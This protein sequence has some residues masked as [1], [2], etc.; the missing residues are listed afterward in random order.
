MGRLD[1]LRRGRRRGRRGG[2]CDRRRRGYGRHRGRRGRGSRLLLPAEEALLALRETLL[3]LDHAL[4]GRGDCLLFLRDAL[5]AGQELLATLDLLIDNRLLLVQKIEDFLLSRDDFTLSSRNLPARG[6]VLRVFAGQFLFAADE[7]LDP[8]RSVLLSAPKLRFLLED[9]LLRCLEVLLALP[10]L[11]LHRREFL[12]PGA[13]PLLTTDDGV[14][15]IGE[16]R[17]PLPA[18]APAALARASPPSPRGRLRA[19]PPPS[20]GS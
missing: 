5:L 8:L 20:R 18:R 3:L 16:R 19:S 12:F 17:T 13:K 2:S 14:P 6:G 4:L 9:L 15:L 7:A 1:F 10:E 11:P